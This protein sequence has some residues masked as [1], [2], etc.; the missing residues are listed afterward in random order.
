LSLRL[1]A[2]RLLLLELLR[3]LLLQ[4]PAGLQPAISQ[5]EGAAPILILRLL[6]LLPRRCW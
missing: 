4:H 5:G 2:W 3:C 1:L 6:M